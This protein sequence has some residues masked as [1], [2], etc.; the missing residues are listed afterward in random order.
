[1]D[2]DNLENILKSS[3][4]DRLQMIHAQPELHA[5]LRSGLGDAA[6]ADYQRLARR[7]DKRHLSVQHA[8][9]L[10]FIPGVMG[11][12]LA[13]KNRGG[14]WWLDLRGLNYIDQLR[15]SADGSQDFVRSEEHTS[16][17]SHQ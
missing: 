16:E 5:E 8:P 12:L 11:S 6:F 4:S 2:S 9:N 13:S 17:L 14:L 15:L 7:V 1:M 3:T 10:I